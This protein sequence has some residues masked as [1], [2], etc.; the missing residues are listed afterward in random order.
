[1]YIFLLTRCLLALHVKNNSP[2]RLLTYILICFS[3]QLGNPLY[4]YAHQTK[5]VLEESHFMESGKETIC[6]KLT[7]SH[8]TVGNHFGIRVP[9]VRVEMKNL[10]DET[11]E[12]PCQGLPMLLSL[13]IILT[14]GEE[15]IIRGVGVGDRV[16][17]SMCSLKPGETMIVE[18]S[19]L[20]NGPGET[21]IEP[22]SYIAAVCIIPQGELG[23]SSTFADRFGGQCTNSIELRVSKI[24]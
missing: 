10:S 6:F 17:I 16:P 2:G 4:L 5:T 11:M 20:E 3:F 19:P 7:L 18:M 24:S 13:Q 23:Q 21:P 9:I 1:M 15:R 14:R 8:R 22:G 12:V